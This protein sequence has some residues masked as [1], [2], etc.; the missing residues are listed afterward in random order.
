MGL[1]ELDGTLSLGKGNDT[2]ESVGILALAFLGD[3]VYEQFIRHKL[4]NSG[5]VKTAAL[6][7]AASTLA[8][9]AKQAELA[10]RIE[11]FLT[12]EESLVLKRGRNAKT[13]H[14]PRG[15]TLHYRWATGLEAL[16]GYL[17]H[18]GQIERLNQILNELWQ[19][20]G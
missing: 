16:L 18:H 5:M 12:V 15:D 8:C 13:K 11:P 1:T 6:S 14:Q 19:M 7:E 17:S 4:L 2:P 10:H 3:A 9:A 20:R